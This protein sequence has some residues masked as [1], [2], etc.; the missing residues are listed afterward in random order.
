MAPEHPFP[1]PFDDSLSAL[2]GLTSEKMRTTLNL[3][4]DVRVGV[5]GL[6][7]GGGLAAPVA[8]AAP[9]HGVKLAGQF[10]GIPMLSPPGTFPSHSFFADCKILSAASLTKTT[11][12][13]FLAFR[14]GH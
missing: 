2:V 8:L 9:L 7:A 11:V 6:S 14:Q 3:I 10:L 4:E 1:A 5:F 13:A 12:G